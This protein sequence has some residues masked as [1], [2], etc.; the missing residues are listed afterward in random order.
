MVQPGE[1]GLP[2][3]QTP[4]P[5]SETS[6]LTE[7]EYSD[8]FLKFIPSVGKNLNVF[9]LLD[10]SKTPSD[11]YGVTAR[12]LAPIIDGDLKSAAWYFFGPTKLVGDIQV[13]TQHYY[14]NCEERETPVYASK[15]TQKGKDLG[16]PAAGLM[17]DFALRHGIVLERIFLDNTFS[18]SHP[19]NDKIRERLAFLKEMSQSE[20]EYRQDNYRE[21][22][23]HRYYPRLATAW[24]LSQLGWAEAKEERDDEDLRSAYSYK[25]NPAG[26]EA[27]TEL[28]TIIDVIKSGDSDGLARGQE[29]ATE[30]SQDPDKMQQLMV[31]VKDSRERFG[32]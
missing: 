6:V 9:Y 12:P 17:A 13:G 31:L 7:Q 22:D 28:F 2:S 1:R 23:D 8:D 5:N 11:G 15:L 32:L 4:A 16:V 14:A 26:R 3:S 24:G 10:M 30:I 27:L 21:F 18:C 19:G 29:F 25:I 20:E